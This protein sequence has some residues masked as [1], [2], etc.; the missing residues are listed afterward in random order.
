MNLT[1]LKNLTKLYK[2]ENLKNNFQFG[3][4][5]TDLIRFLFSDDQIISETSETDINLP[6]VIEPEIKSTTKSESKQFLQNPKNP[7]KLMVIFVG[8]PK[9]GK[10][11]MSI[12]ILQNLKTANIK[13]KFIETPSGLE[14]N[15]KLE[16]LKY[17]NN[18]SNASKLPFDVII[19]NGNNYTSTIRNSIKKIAND[20]NFNILYV[21]FKHSEDTSG[22]FDNYKNYCKKTILSRTDAININVNLDKAVE[23]FNILTQDE[24]EFGK[25]LKIFINYSRT[26]NINDIIMKIKEILT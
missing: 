9:C 18:I 1:N 16:E 5:S 26:K 21:D 15:K 6:I 14:E 19:C 24:L 8:L 17:I 2:S 11:Q 4:S 25:Y 23:N 12:Q 10:T 13:T 3:G 7:S 20:N 22:S